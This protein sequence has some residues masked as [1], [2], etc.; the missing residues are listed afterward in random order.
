MNNLFWHKLCE[1]FN[2][3]VLSIAGHVFFDIVFDAFDVI[4]MLSDL[5]IE[6]HDLIGILDLEFLEFFFGEL[7]LVKSLKAANEGFLAFLE[8]SD[9]HL[10]FS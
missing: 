6:I 10:H 5:L 3:Q 9:G 1:I 7:F 4:A 2:N 8:M